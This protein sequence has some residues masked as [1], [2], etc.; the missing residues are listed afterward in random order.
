MGRDLANDQAVEE[1]AKIAGVLLAHGEMTPEEYEMVKEAFLGRLFRAGLTKSRGAVQALRRRGSE[2]V[3]KARMGLSGAKQRAKGALGK[4]KP[5]PKPTVGGAAARPNAPGVFRRRGGKVTPVKQAPQGAAPKP[6][7]EQ[8]RRRRPAPQAQPTSAQPTGGHPYRTQAQ[9]V[10]AK[11]AAKAPAS[12]VAS[13]SPTGTVGPGATTGSRAGQVRPA[14][15]MPKSREARKA[16]KQQQAAAAAQQAPAAAAADPSGKGFGW[17]RAALYG[18]LGLGA[19]GLYKGVGWGARQL[20]Q[21]S[22]TPMAYG[23]GWSPT[24][25]GYGPNPYGSGIPNMGMGA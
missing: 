7:V 6:K 3:L 9:T 5:A 18:G 23:G 21:T 20:E 10:A 11:P 15:Q 24:A 14:D 12:Q 13:A 17:G 19:Y 4:L 1:L 8:V 22:A 25:Y 16:V 2:G